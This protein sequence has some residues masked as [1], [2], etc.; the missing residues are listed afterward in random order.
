[1][2][3]QELETIGIGTKESMKLEP[4]KVKI[5]KASVE[6]VGDKGNKKVVCLVEHPKADSPI[7]VSSAKIEFKG[8][9]V[10]GGLWF[11]QDEDNLIR[12]GSTLANFLSFMNVPNI[13]ELE[14]KEVLTTEDEAGYL[15]F[16]AY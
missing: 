1:M 12:K 10:V 16:K 15:V 13:K 8:K 9:L 11:N 2:E 5:V 14:G 6:S 3:T 4:E 7:Q